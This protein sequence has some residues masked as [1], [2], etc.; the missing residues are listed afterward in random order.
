MKSICVYCKKGNFDCQCGADTFF[1]SCE[2]YEREQE[3]VAS[4]ARL[5]QQQIEEDR[6]RRRHYKRLRNGTWR[7]NL[8]SFLQ[9]G[10]KL[11]RRT[12]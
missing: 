9:I 11:K 5:R 7:I 3:E 2:Q 10:R 12:G 4:S 6:E 1:I 8:G